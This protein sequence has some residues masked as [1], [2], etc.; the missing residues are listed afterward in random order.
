MCPGVDTV[1]KNEYQINP[2]GKGGRCVRLTMSRNL[3]GLK[4]LE[5]F[6][7]VQACNGTAL[8]LLWVKM[9]T[10]WLAVSIGSRIPLENLKVILLRISEVSRS[11]WNLKLHYRN[12]HL[13]L[14]RVT[15]Q[16][17]TLLHIL[18]IYSHLRVNLTSGFL[19]DNDLS[20]ACHTP[21]PSHPL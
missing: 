3:G 4:L 10:I 15:I 17:T 14:S 7:P 16:R 2:G 13:L 11:F 6:G 21:R 9:F 8:T 18:I 1:F 20:N 12:R 5:P 19:T